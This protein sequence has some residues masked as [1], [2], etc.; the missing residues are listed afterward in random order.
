MSISL[1]KNGSLQISR[2]QDSS[3]NTNS[4]VGEMESEITTKRLKDNFSSKEE[5]HL[6]MASKDQLI[7][8]LSLEFFNNF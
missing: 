5:I 8:Y 2:S 7:A 1:E 4:N 6:K 3:H